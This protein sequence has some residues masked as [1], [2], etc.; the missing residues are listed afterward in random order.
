MRVMTPEDRR[1]FTCKNGENRRNV[2]TPFTLE[3]DF[4]EIKKNLHVHDMEF[5]RLSDMSTSFQDVIRMVE[6]TGQSLL[7]VAKGL[8]DCQGPFPQVGMT[9]GPAFVDLMRL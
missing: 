5:V 3:M 9:L 1:Y 4:S 6:L 7:V 8:R 2:L